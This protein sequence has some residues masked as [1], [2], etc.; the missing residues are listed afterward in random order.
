MVR[1]F[2]IGKSTFVE[3]RSDSRRGCAKLQVDNRHEG[4]PNLT[5]M[6]DT[7]V[8]ATG[9]LSTQLIPLVLAYEYI[10]SSISLLHS[11]C[12]EKW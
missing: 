1:S 4:V 11:F 9:S 8:P 12:V 7:R 6:N 3:L 10:R 2:E 5:S